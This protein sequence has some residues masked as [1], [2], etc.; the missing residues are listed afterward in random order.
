VFW[1]S[2]AGKR[3]AWAKIP[4]AEGS[5]IRIEFRRTIVDHAGAPAHAA[6]YIRERRVFL[7]TGLKSKPYEFARI[8]AHELFHF[9]WPRLGN[10]KRRSYEDLVAGEMRQRRGGE[11][12]WSSE[13]RKQKLTVRDRARRTR[14]WRDYCCESFCD[15]AAWLYA[16]VGRHA[17]FTLSKKARRARQDWFRR[18]GLDAGIPI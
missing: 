2:Y 12:G 10:A 4:P 14:R 16:G 1:P 3:P 5:P 13:W 8:F 7:E 9:V 17:E 18:S 11:L 15:T 6:T